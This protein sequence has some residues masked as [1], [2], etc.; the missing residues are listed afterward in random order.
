[1]LTDYFSFHN[2]YAKLFSVGLTS[3]S[4]VLR[5]WKSYLLLNMP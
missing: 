2:G 5:K 1:M 3:Q 4:E